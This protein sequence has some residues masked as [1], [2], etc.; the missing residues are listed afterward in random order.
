[1]PYYFSHTV[2][3]VQI[4]LYVLGEAPFIHARYSHLLDSIIDIANLLKYCN[5]MFER[6]WLVKKNIDFGIH[7]RFPGCRKIYIYMCIETGYPPKGL[8]LAIYHLIYG[9]DTIWG[10]AKTPHPFNHIFGADRILEH[11]IQ[12]S[13]MQGRTRGRKGERKTL[14]YVAKPPHASRARKGEAQGVLSFQN[15]NGIFANPHIFYG[16]L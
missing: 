13:K 7:I 3:F 10:F 4:N 1:M 8:V 16:S 14:P 5:A 11:D 15:L 9:I 12:A 2:N 6:R